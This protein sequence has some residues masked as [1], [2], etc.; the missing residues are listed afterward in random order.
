MKCNPHV[1]IYSGRVQW[2]LWLCPFSSSLQL[3]STKKNA[4]K[5][6]VAG[7]ICHRISLITNIYFAVFKFLSRSFCMHFWRFMWKRRRLA[8]DRHEKRYFILEDGTSLWLCVASSSSECL[9][10]VKMLDNFTYS[11]HLLARR[12]AW[13]QSMNVEWDPATKSHHRKHIIKLSKLSRL[14]FGL[15]NGDKL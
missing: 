14:N 9:R 5:E 6:G 3:S 11:Y 15:A 8:W 2:N 12:L 10:E 4:F 7:V 13:L 1:W